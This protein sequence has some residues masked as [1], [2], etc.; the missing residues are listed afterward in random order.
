MKIKWTITVNRTFWSV[1]ECRAVI[2][3]H[4]DCPSVFSVESWL[5]HLFVMGLWE[6][7]WSSVSFRSITHHQNI[8]ILPL[9]V[10]ELSE[11]TTKQKTKPKANKSE[12][13]QQGGS[14]ADLCPR[15]YQACS[16]LLNSHCNQNKGNTC[17]PSCD[18]FKPKIKFSRIT[19]T[20]EVCLLSCFLPQ[21]GVM[22]SFPFKATQLFLTNVH[23]VSVKIK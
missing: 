4:P 10:S 2:F 18:V 3:T 8:I 14:K 22:T 20:L 19:Q 23:K 1:L 13:S 15:C 5:C 11:Y 21:T 6:D 9:V 12:W 16:F 17:F 7:H